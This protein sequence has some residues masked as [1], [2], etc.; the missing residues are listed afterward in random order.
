MVTEHA[1]SPTIL[2]RLKEVSCSTLRRKMERG[3]G[4]KFLVASEKKRGS[5]SRAIL[6]LKVRIIM[7]PTALAS[8]YYLGGHLGR[9]KTAQKIKA[10]FYWKTIWTDIQEFVQHCEVCQRAND[11]KFQKAT[12]PLHPIPV[13]S[14]VWDQVMNKIIIQLHYCASN[15][16]LALI[17]LVHYQK[18]LKATNI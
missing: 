3:I 7:R 9:D 5:S 1:Q 17:L 11:S 16:R 2:I 4:S 18:Q 13:K 10:R 14:K 8:C 6:R 15:K 12:A